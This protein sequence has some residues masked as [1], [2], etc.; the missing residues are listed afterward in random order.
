M[1]HI[2]RVPNRL[3]RPQLAARSRPS[4]NTAS[5]PRLLSSSP[6]SPF[7]SS[8]THR[9]ALEHPTMS[10][11]FTIPKTQTAAVVPAH[12]SPL[13]IRHDHPVVQPE[14]LKPG[15]CLVKLISTGV[16]HTDLHCAK[17]DWPV[18]SIVPLVGG[19]EGVGTVVAIGAHTAGSPVKLGDRVG[20]KWLASSCLKCEFC[21]KGLEQVCPKGQ[22]SGFTIDGT[23]QEYC[24]SDVQ[25]VTPIP[26]NLDSAE[27]ASILCAGITVYRA[28][29]Y[30]KSQIGDW[31]VFPGAGGG[32][33]HLAV[34]YAAAMGLR[35]LA[36][37]TG[38]EKKDL[39]M[40]LGAEKWIDFKESKDLV[41]DIIAATDGLG[42]HTAVITA[43]TSAAYE[44]AVDYLRP[45]GTLMAVGLPGHATLN[46]GIFQTVVKSINIQG[47]YVG[48]RQD[49]FE[50]LD[51]ASRGKVKV[52]FKT[53]PLEALKETYEAL[54]AGTIA[55]RIVLN[56]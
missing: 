8:H 42:P 26:D 55:G 38:A 35:V 29:K 9:R 27:A 28:I 50:A 36:I 6:S 20:I 49:A 15:E 10:P 51:I 3:L 54:E 5:F 47:S 31:I 33:G 21:R 24:R 32:L 45:G 43:A 22:Y 13:E 25:H 56:F 39:V 16:C 23:F 18:A 40:S 4:I 34:Q 19:H 30:S 48:N 12:G 52:V 46:A 41:K 53:K 2:I 11:Q 14:D 17:N 37:D 44:Q 7:Q 1:N